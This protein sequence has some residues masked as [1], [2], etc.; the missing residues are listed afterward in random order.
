L[1]GRR[2]S[3]SKIGM[4]TGK[5]EAPVP[6]ISIESWACAPSAR[7]ASRPARK[8][9]NACSV[10]IMRGFLQP[11]IIDMTDSIVRQR[12][13]FQFEGTLELVLVVRQRQRARAPDRALDGLVEGGHAGRALEADI[14]HFAT[15]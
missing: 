7:L 6:V 3:F 10:L 9:R 4:M 1:C 12:T 11:R 5:R 2:P 14:E 15:R 8:R 13:E